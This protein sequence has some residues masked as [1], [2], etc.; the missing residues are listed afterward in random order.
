MF[1]FLV[2]AVLTALTVAQPDTAAYGPLV[3][4]GPGY[5]L[6]RDQP[7]YVIGGACQPSWCAGVHRQIR[8]GQPVWV[9]MAGLQVETVTYC[10]HEDGC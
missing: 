8:V 5:V 4:A 10:P 2:A 3:A 6:V 7:G 1:G 9:D